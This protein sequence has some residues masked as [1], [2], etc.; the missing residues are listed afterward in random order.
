[1]IRSTFAGFTTAHLAMR[2]SQKALDVTGQNISNINTVGY[3]R[4]NVDLMSLKMNGTDRY[5]SPYNSGVGHG[6]IVTGISQTRDPFLDLRFRT[7]IANVGEADVKVG[8]LKELETIFDEITKE[9]LQSQM[10]DFSS[11]LQKLSTQVGNKEFD[12]MV[13]SSAEVITK[14]FNQYAK[15]V[16]T[17]KSDQVYNLENVEIPKINDILKNIEELNVSIKNNHIHGNPAL[18]LQD[19]R[20]LLLDELSSYVKIDVKYHT[21]NVSDSLSVDKL[22]ID[23]IGKD[24]NKLALIDD[25]LCSNFDVSKDMNTGK[26]VI[27]LTDTLGNTHADMNEHII[28]GSLKSSLNMLNCSGEF[29]SPPNSTRG[30]GY[31]SKMLDLLANKFSEIL[32]EAN[33]IDNGTN[34]NLF[35]TNDKTNKITAQNITIADGWASGNYGIFP[36]KDSL[37]TPPAPVG[38]NDNILHMISLL[39]SKHEYQIDNSNGVPGDKVTLFRGSFQECFTNMGSVL[40]LDIKSSSSILDNYVAVTKEIANARDSISAVSLDEEGINLLHFQKSYN[41]AARLMTT[42]DEALNTIINNMGIVGR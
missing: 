15:Q 41:A 37:K 35:G 30:T 16:E 25:N 21:V 27:S 4:Q 42:L 13:K 17:V 39:S 3:T 8:N 40:G 7:E 36:S 33:N 38:Q 6:V 19:Q 2:A 20:N 26:M 5:S 34:Y 10:S 11:M 1:M 12:N 31:Y 9:G 23:L 18:E 22:H 28:T 32:N 24:G 29:D 14:L